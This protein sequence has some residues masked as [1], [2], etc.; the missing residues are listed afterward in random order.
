MI[1]IIGGGPVGNFLAYNLAKQGKKV[2]VFEEHKTVGKP[3]ACT[4]IMTSH[5]KDLIDVPKDFLVNTINQ[6]NV[7]SPD[8]NFV[9]IR[10]KKNYI[11]DRT[12]FDSHLAKMA[13]DEGAKYFTG[14]RLFDFE[15]VDSSFK[16]GFKDSVEKGFDSIVGADGPSS[17]VA[18]TAG[19]YNNRNF[20]TGHQARV[21][22]DQRINPNIV[23]FFLDVGY[24]GWLVPEDDRTARVGVA[25]YKHAQFHFKELMKLRH[26]KILEWQS[27]VIPLYD[28]SVVTEKDGVYLVGDAA[29]QVKATTYGGIIPSMIASKELANVLVNGGSYE[30]NWRN[31]I[32]KELGLHL[33]LRKMLDK[34][35]VKD[36]NNLIKLC[37]QERINNLIGDCDREFPSKLLF[38]MFMKDPRFIQF[39]K[40]FFKRK[41]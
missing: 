28:P 13:V 26:G 4:G 21:K 7:F 14:K 30:K 33:L 40:V 10:L 11:V 12:L 17:I 3:V 37:Q 9:N 20:I 35:G 41:S 18:R 5:L 38:K 19:L 23:E 31:K 16:L 1:G 29:T 2:S 6:T 36:F 15:K 34:F 8:G 24:I 32:G 27:G 25:S 39:A 22:M